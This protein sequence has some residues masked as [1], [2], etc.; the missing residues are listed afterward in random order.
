MRAL[1]VLAALTHIFSCNTSFGQSIKKF[2]SS[3]KEHV[4][5]DRLL[6]EEI[7]IIFHNPYYSENDDKCIYPIK[8]LRYADADVVITIGN[9]PGATCHA[10]EASMSAYVLVRSP[11]GGRVVARFLDFGTSGAFGDPGQIYSL[12]ILGHDALSIEHGYMAQGYSSNNLDFYVFDAGRLHHLEPSLPL[13]ADNSG[14]MDDS[15]KAVSVS[16]AWII[17]PTRPDR[18]IIRYKVSVG[19]KTKNIEASWAVKGDKMTLEE[20]S[21]PPELARA[22]GNE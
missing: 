1:I 2:C 13:S 15:T 22:S 21:V 10:C 6:S 12:Q 17:E 7:P 5:N 20:G 11:S 4:Q 9:S 16:G 3:A 19:G 14:A 18:I 8:V